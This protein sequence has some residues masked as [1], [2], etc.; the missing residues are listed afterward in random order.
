M[1]IL[2]II[3]SHPQ[4][5]NIQ[6]AIELILTLAD[7]NQSVRVVLSFELLNIFYELEHNLVK[8]LKQFELFDIECFI[9]KNDG[10]IK[11]NE[12]LNFAMGIDNKMFKQIIANADKVITI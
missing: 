8:Q 3:K 5:V 1:S 2:V 6:D 10:L 9:Y 7:L 4:K 12:Q 11:I